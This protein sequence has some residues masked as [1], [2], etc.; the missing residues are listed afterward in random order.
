M[1]D[2]MASVVARQQFEKTP[3]SVKSLVWGHF[4]F[5]VEYNHE[6]TK[7]VDRKLSGSTV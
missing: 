6:G 5:G 1:A 4:G 3:S 7:T 2:S